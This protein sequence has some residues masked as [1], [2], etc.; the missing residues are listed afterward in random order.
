[1][2]GI[3]LVETHLFSFLILMPREK[4]WRVTI[5][6]RKSTMRSVFPLHSVFCL[7][8]IR[9]VVVLFVVVIL[10][11]FLLF[12]DSTSYLHKYVLEIVRNNVAF[13]GIR[14]VFGVGTVNMDLHNKPVGNEN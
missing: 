1:M 11:F 5:R 2:A 7:G 9:N 14:Y 12:Y 6:K 4:H 13:S 10:I 8:P 3:L